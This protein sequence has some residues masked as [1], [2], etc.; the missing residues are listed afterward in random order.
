MKEKRYTPNGQ[1]RT[2]ESA[3]FQARFDGVGVCPC[4][5][6]SVAVGDA[7]LFVRY[8]LGH[9]CPK[10]EG[11]KIVTHENCFDALPESR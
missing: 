8:P 5:N 1:R 4:C 10:D 11:P 6:R 2:R 9:R 3:T 7:V